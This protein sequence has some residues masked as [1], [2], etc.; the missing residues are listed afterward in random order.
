MTEPLCIRSRVMGSPML[1]RRN[2]VYLIASCFAPAAFRAIAAVV[3]ERD[4]VK[5]TDRGKR[6]LSAEM[7]AAG[8]EQR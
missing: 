3:R 2:L 6:A 4:S 5:A 1:T 8:G 7:M